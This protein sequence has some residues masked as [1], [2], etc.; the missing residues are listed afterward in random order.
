MSHPWL[1]ELPW[2]S[3]VSPQRL[4]SR[5][6]RV[7]APQHHHTS[8]W[9]Y[10]KVTPYVLQLSRV[11]GFLEP[12]TSSPT[13]V[14][15]LLLS[16]LVRSVT[17][18]ASRAQRRESFTKSFSAPALLDLRLD[19]P[20]QRMSV[21]PSVYLYPSEHVSITWYGHDVIFMEEKKNRVIAS[22]WNAHAWPC[23][24]LFDP[25]RPKVETSSTTSC[26]IQLH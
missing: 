20:V 12:S 23:L 3:P 4:L 25:T 19:T 16:P 14:M 13:T 1:I 5:T 17:T 9:I 8:L 26:Q 18:P 10:R 11:Q 2:Y 22:P 7:T 15:G 21:K 6:H 24:T